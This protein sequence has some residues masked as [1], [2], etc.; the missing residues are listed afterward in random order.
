MTMLSMALTSRI[1]VY[2]D[3]LPRV[4]EKEAVVVS[5]VVCDN[6]YGRA[7]ET[8]IL[9]GNIRLMMELLAEDGRSIDDVLVIGKKGSVTLYA[10]TL[11]YRP[12][13]RLDKSQDTTYS[14]S[15][16]MGVCG[17]YA[18]LGSDYYSSMSSQA[19]NIGGGSYFGGDSHYEMP[20]MPPNG[21]HYGLSSDL[22][23][24][25]YVLGTPLMI[26]SRAGNKKIVAKLLDCGA[27]PNV[28]IKVADYTYSVYAGPVPNSGLWGFKRPYM[29]A[30]LD[31][32]MGK[33]QNDIARADEIAKMLIDRGA[34]FIKDEDDYG[35]NMLWDVA[36]V[37]STYLLAEMV[38]RGFDINHEDNQGN[39]VLD[40]CSGSTPRFWRQLEELGAKGNG[41]RS[42]ANEVDGTRT[43]P[44]LVL[45]S[46][47][48]LP[49]F[50]SNPQYR[51]VPAQQPT[52]LPS[53][54]TKPDNS[55][56]IAALQHR[57][58]ALRMEL[59]DARAN[60]QI[61]TLQGTGWVTASMHEQ[62]IMQEI[63]NCER[64]I[65]ELR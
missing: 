32:Y 8:A 40:Y 42:N 55:V 14:S 46:N 50:H 17:G 7:I 63:S 4:P 57:L 13:R 60:R 54:Q 64:R 25:H 2:G 21:A 20:Q 49:T 53:V 9:E 19:Y 18:F 61:A 23:S 41:K 35:R 62:Q 44:T 37:E 24:D 6:N 59:E 26:A 15:G 65:M 30:L 33:N 29:C 10:K 1:V 52:V 11:Y 27:N 48:P 28:F 22:M 3:N 38:K 16:V 47:P 34:G 43:Q 58:L 5:S 39:T 31:C 51:Y 45:E 36:R 56:E 12:Q